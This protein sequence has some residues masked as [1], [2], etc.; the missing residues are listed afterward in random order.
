MSEKDYNITED[1]AY[2]VGYAK[3]LKD[4]REQFYNDVE[5]AIGFLL[6][7]KQSMPITYRAYLT[8]DAERAI[9]DLD[10]WLGHA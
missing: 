4:Q 8:R 10:Y 3:A 7:L 1:P 5:L 9:Y 2:K 6:K